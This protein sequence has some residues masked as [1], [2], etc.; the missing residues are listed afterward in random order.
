MKKLSQQAF[1]QIKEWIYRNARALDLALFQ[2]HF[3]NGSKDNVLTALSYYQ[4]SDG[5]F[6]NTIDPDNWNPNSTPY[7]AQIVIKMLRQIDFTD[8]THPIY[9]GIFRY[10]ENT[11]HKADYGWFFTIPSNNDYPHGVWWDH[12]ADTN[13]YESTGTTASLCGFILRYGEKNTNL[14]NIAISYIETLIEKLKKSTYYGAMGVAGYCELLEDIDGAGLIEHF[15]YE[16]LCDKISY[17][18]R[19]KIQKE[20]DDFMSNPLEFVLSPYSRYYEENKKEVNNALDILID[21]KPEGGI[22]PIPW[23]WYNNNK[24]PNE[25]SISEN[26]WK[27]AKAI[28]KL[29]QLRSFGCLSL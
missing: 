19:E 18:V 15:D 27:C 4:N 17:L 24:Y 12:N 8:I 20:Q 22:W 10:L 3:E 25:F 28:D 7:N 1:Q 9:K 6:G 2:Y 11:E 29:M 21:Q 13:T 23:E 26:W 16:Y 14:Y 5:G